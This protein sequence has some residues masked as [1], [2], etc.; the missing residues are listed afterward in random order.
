MYIYVLG[1]NVR[2]KVCSKI[3][4]NNIYKH[5]NMSFKMKR[6][7]S[8]IKFFSKTNGKFIEIYYFNWFHNIN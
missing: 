3:N 8:L 2:D 1:R 5:K 4:Y 6:L 7:D